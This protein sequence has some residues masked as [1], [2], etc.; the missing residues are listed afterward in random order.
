MHF[1]KEY[2]QEEISTLGKNKCVRNATKYSVL[3]EESFLRE[4]FQSWKSGN[5]DKAVI[6]SALHDASLDNILSSNYANS[7]EE[8]FRLRLRSKFEEMPDRFAEQLAACAC[9]ICRW[10]KP[11]RTMLTREFE[12]ALISHAKSMSSMPQSAREVFTDMGLA[13]ESKLMTSFR[14]TV[15]YRELILGCQKGSADKEAVRQK[16][17]GG[18]N[19]EAYTGNPF[20]AKV[21]A[22]SVV[23]TDAFYGLA[24]FLPELNTK[25]LLTLFEVDTSGIS[26]A[27]LYS[28]EKQRHD[29]QCT[30]EI[31]VPVSPSSI[32]ILK[33]VVK[34]QNTA[35]RENFAQTKAL[36]PGLTCLQKKALCRQ[37]S[38]Y[39]STD[40]Y[41]AGLSRSEIIRAA[42]IRHT[43]YYKALHKANYGLQEER[44]KAQDEEDLKALKAVV[45]YKGFEKGVRQIYMMLPDLTGRHMAISKIRRL[46]RS[47][48][49]R[50]KIREPN[51]QHQSRQK[52]L[53]EN[54]RPN[55]LQRKFRLHRPGEV[56]QS[57]VTYLN[58]GPMESM[59]AYASSCI[60]PATGRL[61]VFNIS[62]NNDLQLALD[63][64]TRLADYPTLED[65]LFHTDQGILYLS[66]VF[67]AEV[68]K[69]GMQQSMSKRGNCWDN[70]VCESFFS[71]FK[72]EVPY[73]KCQTYEELEAMIN[74][75]A[76]YYNNDRHQWDRMK[77]TPAEFEKYLNSLSDEDFQK[78][79]DL[80]TAKYDR[81]KKHAESLA[82][83]RNKTNGV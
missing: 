78:Y 29:R 28:I 12:D 13:E 56:R 67:Q 82:I 64:L 46:L 11:D 69:M 38:E 24:A 70:A 14:M 51:P 43:A 71:V 59:R 18:I 76:D 44:K 20:V 17:E 80:E 40:E 35:I 23:M 68:A 1:A 42:G 15:L 58:Y 31:A 60:D 63:T 33:N 10:Y 36:V 30:G 81:M 26:A 55:L 7:I 34:A 4:V 32:R 73:W 75:Y 27:G 66:P 3:L 53:K 61:L 52:F 25:T 21:N 79:I 77:M 41:P 72:T 22:R 49:I 19:A 65:A 8:G 74:S 45:E 9:G 50:T 2:T 39:P 62:P 6:T 16:T 54:V 5:N 83:A 57:D 48:G 47:A 37:L